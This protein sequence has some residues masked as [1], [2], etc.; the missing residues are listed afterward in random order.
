MNLKVDPGWRSVHMVGMGGAGMSA[1]A[2]LL[3]GAG[4][5]VTGSDARESAALELL[6]SLG[7]EA[8]VGHW[9]ERVDG[10]DAVIVSAAVPPTNPEIERAALLGIPVVWRGEALGRILR[11][12]RTVA[13][14]G[15]HGKTTT[16]SMIASIVRGASLDPT[17]ALGANLSDGSPGG[18]LGS[19]EVAVVEADEAYGSFLH[20]EPA[21]A[22][23]TNVDRDHLDHF[24]DWDSLKAAFRTFMERASEKLIVCA[25]DPV[26]VELSEELEPTSYGFH[27]QA[28]IG[29]DELVCSA[30]GSTF[31][32]KSGG[33]PC[34]RVTLAVAGRHNALNAL[35]AAAACLQVGV[36][37]ESVIEGLGDFRGVSRRFEFRGRFHGAD[38]VDDY[39]HHPAEIEAT[40]AAARCGP[41]SRIVAVFQPH[42]YSRTADLWNEFGA[43][44]AAADLVVVTDV[45]G[46]REDPVPG[47]TGKLIVESV[48][49][50]APGRQVAYLPRLNEAAAFVREKILPGDLVLTLGAG[51]ITTLPDRL[52]GSLPKR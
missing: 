10:A 41:W 35:G 20:L 49:D 13:V 3:A 12:F 50:H 43:A 27:P 24:G 14:S 25:D 4:M 52:A 39:A 29:G 21:V 1:I 17:Y 32:M 34:G 22:L 26:A 51:D 19:G 40:L 33:V 38:I 8:H 2:H 31:R 23:V 11:G 42:L 7:I 5:R 15:T 47:V 9:G 44:L 37:L 45:Y 30:S 48:C 36:P 6:R 28:R 16:S 46:A 18:F